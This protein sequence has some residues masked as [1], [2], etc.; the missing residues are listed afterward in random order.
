MPSR[1]RLWTAVLLLGLLLAGAFALFSVLGAFLIDF[2]DD[3]GDRGFWIGFL[4]AAAAFLA[5]GLWAA[6]RSRW[7]A[8]ALLAIGAILG[9]LPTFWTVIVPIAALALVVLAIL[10]A[11]SPTASARQAG[12]SS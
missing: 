11:R 1:T 4:L 12:L 3:G 8:V 6:R 7:L 2:E 9:S 10:W 5:V